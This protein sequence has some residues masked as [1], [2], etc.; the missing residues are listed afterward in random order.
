M[1]FQGQILEAG[2]TYSTDGNADADTVVE[3]ML[4][5]P[6]EAQVGGQS[7]AAPGVLEQ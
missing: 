5:E 1:I 4:G 7:A 3:D 6:Q 2:R